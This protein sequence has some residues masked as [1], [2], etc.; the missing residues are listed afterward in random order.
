MKKP[1]GLL[2]I[3][4]AICVSKV[5]SQFYIG[6]SNSY[7]NQS[8]QLAKASIQPDES[9]STKISK[10]EPN[11]E[12]SSKNG[13][14][15]AKNTTKKI[16]LFEKVVLKNQTESTSSILMAY[17]NYLKELQIDIYYN[18][19]K[20]SIFKSNVDMLRL[21]VKGNPANFSPST[22][23]TGYLNLNLTNP[24]ASQ[25]TLSFGK[26]DSSFNYF[27]A[28]QT[29][30]EILSISMEFIAYRDGPESLIELWLSD[31]HSLKILYKIDQKLTKR[32]HEETKPAANEDKDTTK[33]DPK[34]DQTSP[35]STIEFL[36][37][38][39]NYEGH[40]EKALEKRSLVILLSL[41]CIA[42][43]RFC[44]YRTIEKYN[45]ASV[46]KDAHNFQWFGLYLYN[47][48]F[49]IALYTIPLRSIAS[50]FDQI[51]YI[52]L[53]TVY[54]LGDL[55]LARKAFK[56]LFLSKKH[57]KSACHFIEGLTKQKTKLVSFYLMQLWVG[58]CFVSPVFF[59]DFPVVLA[60]NL[61]LDIKR[62]RNREIQKS[63]GLSILVGCFLNLTLFNVVFLTGIYSTTFNIVYGDPRYPIIR[64]LVPYAFS[65]ILVAISA[66]NKFRYRRRRLRLWRIGLE[67]KD[68]AKLKPESK[69]Q[70]YFG[71]K[72]IDTYLENEGHRCHV[73]FSSR[74]L[75]SIQ[76]LK[77]LF[78]ANIQL[79]SYTLPI[80]NL[81]DNCFVMVGDSTDGLGTLIFGLE[82]SNRSGDGSGGVSQPQSLDRKVHWLISMPGRG[83]RAFFDIWV[84][85]QRSRRFLGLYKPIRSPR[86]QFKLINK[87]TRK[88]LLNTHNPG[89]KLLP[90]E[91]KPKSAVL[92]P[93]CDRSSI[94]LF[95]EE[96]LETH[97]FRLRSN[98]SALPEDTVELIQ[99]FKQPLEMPEGVLQALED[100]QFIWTRS[101]FF[102]NF[103]ANYFILFEGD[104][105]DYDY[106]NQAKYHGLEVFRMVVKR[107][108]VMVEP[109][110]EVEEGGL[111]GDDL[112]DSR[113][114]VRVLEEYEL[115]NSL[116]S[117]LEGCLAARKVD[118]FFF[119]SGSKIC[120]VS[121]SLLLVVDFE[122]VEVVGTLEIEGLFDFCSN[123][124]K[125]MRHYYTTFLV[126]WSQRV[127][128]Y[129]IGRYFEDEDEQFSHAKRFIP[130][131][132]PYAS[133]KHCAVIE[134]EQIVD[135][136]LNGDGKGEW[137]LGSW[138]DDHGGL[139]DDRLYSEE[140]DDEF[141]AKKADYGDEDSGEGTELVSIDTGF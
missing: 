44:S 96:G 112:E 110:K 98:H 47:I 53:V 109:S 122:N 124:E 70:L 16:D 28:S 73:P 89:N 116:E 35:I 62:L 71:L 92:S 90:E 34:S 131:N 38:E 125:M 69:I 97:W 23:R 1:L 30:A 65:V 24:N 4:Q 133:F 27:P 75:E 95:I 33:T 41:L 19:P 129:S 3:L 25:V 102:G 117:I 103:M 9:K 63:D 15:Q 12:K 59:L 136:G 82:N 81:V 135:F 7:V 8:L 14:N 36:K 72:S 10:T 107:Q 22:E 128:I 5:S 138:E 114:F 130:N 39:T 140:D 6:Q 94:K 84:A 86:A 120:L 2:L 139:M 67:A 42:Y 115:I 56:Q 134:L 121:Q 64:F 76:S 66:Y 79:A 68:Q 137:Q 85:D 126:D 78:F 48:A 105:N 55:R 80:T 88:V 49:S 91:W 37:I 127:L 18:L 99:A 32:G 52:F 61:A 141:G 51:F 111:I 29:K 101:S 46:Y 106:I 26:A 132:F 118:H 123:S 93:A 58:L 45:F 60:I 83:Y 13:E 57:F 77:G 17:D 104:N 100:K 31:L 108:R 40:N 113:H 87:R 21:R 119:I 43:Y 20:N 50:R 54:N 11:D 74:T